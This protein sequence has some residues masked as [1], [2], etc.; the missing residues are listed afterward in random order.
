MSATCPRLFEAE[1][2]RDGR[3]TGAEVERFQAHAKLCAS[4]KQELASLAALGE[5]LRA[6]EPPTD[7]LHVRRERTRLLGA[8]DERLVPRARSARPRLWLGAAATLA[9]AGAVVLALRFKHPAPTPAAPPAKN[10]GAIS[11]QSG[12]DARWSRQTHAE[13]ET[14]VLE[15][16]ELSIQV[17]RGASPRRLLVVL[18]DGELEDIG[19]TFFVRARAGRTEHVSV[20][21]GVVVLRLHGQAALRLSAGEAWTLAPPAPAPDVVTPPAAS[22]ASLPSVKKP[23]PDPAADFRHAMAALERG[24]NS[25]AATLFAAFAGAHPRDS[26][27]QDA[28]YLRVLAY[29]RAG[30]HAAMQRAAAQYLASYPRGFRRAEVE[31]L[32]REP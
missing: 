24:D 31:P 18:P 1:A 9:V 12:V 29:Q 25:Q 19:T 22:A 3:L 11:V 27:A 2:W 15:S 16:G 10:P 17:V 30:N 4:C 13:R 5:A 28:A 8:F 23:A 21:E 26:R 20:Q 6:S 32:A 7:E 14:I